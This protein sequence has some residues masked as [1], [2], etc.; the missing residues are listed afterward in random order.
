MNEKNNQS[1]TFVYAIYIMT[2]PEKLWQALTDGDF[3]ANYWFGFR[4]KSDWKTGSPIYVRNADFLEGKGNLEGKV[5]A[6]DPPRRLTYTFTRPADPLAAQ[7]KG[8]SQVT[9]EITP[10]GPM[11]K[12]TLT[13]ENLLPQD[14]EKQTNTLRGINNGWPAILSSLKSLLETGQPLSFETLLA[15]FE[16]Q[17]AK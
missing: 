1:Q 12:L 14:L 7:R 8:P 6:C 5:I 16:P 10:V 9:Y 3:S 17:P 11:V 15:Q 13:H 2:T 4:V